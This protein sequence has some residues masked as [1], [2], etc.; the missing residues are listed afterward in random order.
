[1]LSK[2]GPTK[3]KVLDDWSLEFNPLWQPTEQ[4][5]VEMRN[6]QAE[7]DKIY[8]EQQVLT[9]EE[10]TLSRFGGDEYSIETS[11]DLEARK[12]PEEGSQE[13]DD[14]DTVE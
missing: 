5:T 3:G 1:M 10:V 8:I 11:V 13:P 6:K 4:E 14:S 9:P 2:E 12:Q 7:T